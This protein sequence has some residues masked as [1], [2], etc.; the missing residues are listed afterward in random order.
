MRRRRPEKRAIL[1]DPIY[2]ELMVQKFINNLMRGGK[3]VFLKKSFI[4]LWIL[5]NRKLNQILWKCS[6]KQWKM[7]SL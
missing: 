1:P 4:L 6:K 5:L 3:K 2:G 7:L